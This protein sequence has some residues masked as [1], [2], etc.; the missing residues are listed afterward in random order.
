M[1]LLSTLAL[2]TAVAVWGILSVIPSS[3]TS[4]IIEYVLI[5]LVMG[6]IAWFSF[7][8]YLNQLYMY[9]DF[10]RTEPAIEYIQQNSSS[11]DQVLLWGSEAATNFFSQRKSPTRFVYQAPLQQ[12]G[13][14]DEAMIN[15]FLDDVI[16]NQPKFIIDSERNN[17]LFTFPITTETIQQKIASLQAKYCLVRRI[18]FWKFYKYTEAGCSK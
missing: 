11:D 10:T 15:E 8:D 12:E 3:R 13:Y 17:P 5:F 9:R 2:F 6:M 7:D 1:T 16:R 4:T 14:V 18:D